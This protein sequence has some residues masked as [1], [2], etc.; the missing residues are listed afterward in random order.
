MKTLMI[1]D[2]IKNEVIEIQKHENKLRNI[3]CKK[4]IDVQS[5]LFVFGYKYAMSDWN[6]VI[7][8]VKQMSS[9]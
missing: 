4:T 9:R 2:S 3:F 8:F 1:K 6:F 7:V 5:P